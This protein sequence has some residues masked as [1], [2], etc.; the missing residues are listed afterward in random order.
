MN[1]KFIWPLIPVLFVAGPAGTGEF[2]H[3]RT[4]RIPCKKDITIN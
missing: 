4:Q 1:I 2:L 3:G